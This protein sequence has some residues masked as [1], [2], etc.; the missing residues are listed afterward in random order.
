MLLPKGCGMKES[1]RL[2]GAC[3]RP[4]AIKKQSLVCTGDQAR[5]AL[6]THVPRDMLGQPD[7]VLRIHKA[8]PPPFPTPSG[9]G[10]PTSARKQRLSTA[11]SEWH[12]ER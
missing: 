6:L 11:P 9:V 1:A 10:F 3:P 7:A 12:Q 5:V 4:C 8:P 2:G